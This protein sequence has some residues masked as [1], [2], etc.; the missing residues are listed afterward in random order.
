MK[1]A[2]ESD[3]STLD[4]ILHALYEVLSGPARQPRDWERYRTLFMDGARLLVVVAVP[5]EKP[6]V[7]QLTLDDYIR[8]VEP[9]VAVENFWERETTRQSETIGRV[10][11]VLSRYESL[12]DPSGPAFEHGANS[13]QLFYDDSRWWVVSIM[14]NTS[15]NA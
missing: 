12:H 1:A 11:H 5:G 10:A 14:W 8:R 9:I 2:L 7:R 13:M 4:G 15:R 6:H 3:V